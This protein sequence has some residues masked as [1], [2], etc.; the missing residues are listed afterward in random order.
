MDRKAHAR[1][2]YIRPGRCLV[3]LVKHG[4]IRYAPSMTVTVRF[5]PSPTGLIHIGNTRTALFNWLFAKQ[6]DGQFILR[7][8][9]T[10]IARSKQEYADAILRDLEWLGIHPD[11]V[12]YQSKR[13]AAYDEA[14]ERLKK[15]GLLYP[16]YE[17][18][19][20]L[21]L[22]RK[23]L[24]SRRLPPVY[25][26]EALKLSD[27][28]KAILE[29][30]GRR[31]HWRF[32][33]PNFVGDPFKTSR[34]DIHWNDIVRGEETVDLASL[35]DPVLV[36]ED[37]T[38]LYT[39]PSVVDDIGFGVT[40][41]IRGDDHVTNTGV[42]IALFK[43]LGAE[44]PAFG[45]HNLLTSI[46]GEGLSKRTGALSVSGLREAGIEPMAVASLA[47]LTG[48][49]ENIVAARSLDE[50]ATHFDPSHTSKSASKFDPAELDVLNRTLLH[51]MAFDEAKGRLAALGI[52]GDKVESFWR[53]VH[54]NLEK[55]SDAAEWWRII[56]EG[57]AEKPQ[58][59]ADDLGFVRAAF[60]LLPPE[61]WDHE[62]WKAW[63]DRVKQESGRKGRA[64][65]MPLRLALTGRS[66]GPE[67]ADLL[68]LMGRERILA[69]RP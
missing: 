45:H 59:D 19:E 32:L 21:E 64:L 69:R 48:T 40:H 2:G 31:P 3:R 56:E 23:I 30:E 46:S 53:A 17:T 49:S 62:T 42:Q 65:F 15:T 5:A 27:A 33:L 20:E 44:P 54:G 24:L 36:R 25:G 28:E 14:V 68:P 35:S 11:R 13:F 58:F 26:R 41:I 16:C 37:G 66:S 52:A 18:A 67:L 47:V 60:D 50:L 61:P 1:S 6:W 8:D 39:L 12:E 34:T 22:R 7:F 9:D 38:Y 29:K 57:P 55:F 4:S 10:D 63:T 51:G 43:A